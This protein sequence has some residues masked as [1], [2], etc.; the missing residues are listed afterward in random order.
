MLT[1]GLVQGTAGNV[2]ARLP[3]GNVVLTPSSVNYLTM[4]L[5]DLVVCSPDGEVVEGT[6]RGPDVGEGA[7]PLGDEP[8]S[9]DQRDDAL[10]RQALARCS[11]SPR[12][13][14]PRG[15][16]GISWSTSAVTS[17]LA[18]YR[19]TG[20]DD[21]RRGGRRSHGRPAARCSWPT[22]GSSRWAR[23]PADVLHV[24]RPG[25]AATAEI[26]WGAQRLG[27]IRAASRPRPTSSF[28]GPTTANGAHRE[29]LVSPEL[30][31]CGAA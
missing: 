5:D 26:V 23:N 13:P 11:P 10:P 7:A 15:D 18:D 9:R 17:A 8:L 1:S 25:G 28:A 6:P 20:S 22:M 14:N 30:S 31:V 19:T 21:P 29:V 24:R 3:D 16:R 4:T 27:E 2:A 12:Q